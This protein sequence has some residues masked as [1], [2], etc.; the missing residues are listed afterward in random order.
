MKFYFSFLFCFISL[1]SAYAQTTTKIDSLRAA[2]EKHNKQDTTA[3]LLMIEIAQELKDKD[4]N[5]S[6]KFAESA[7]SLSEKIKYLK[8]E[9]KAK[10]MI[11]WRHYQLGNYDLCFDISSKALKI[12]EDIHDFKEKVAILNSLGAAY[13]SQQ[14]YKNAVESFRKGYQIA[15]EN[16]I[17]DQAGRSLNNIAFILYKDNLLQE[18]EEAGKKALAYNLEQENKTFASVAM[19]TLGDI[20]MQRKNY[21]KAESYYKKSLAICEEVKS[22][23][24]TINVLIRLGRINI[25]RKN[26][27]EAIE[28]LLKTENLSRQYSYRDEL[29]ESY[30]YLSHSYKESKQIELAYNYLEKYKF[31]YDS[32]YNDK[33][34]KRIQELS[35]QF[36]AEKKQAQ[37][38][39]LNKEKAIKDEY[40][41]IQKKVNYGLIAGLL[42]VLSGAGYV[43]YNYRAKQKMNTLLE[44]QKQ[45]ITKK[46][47]EV[48][49]QAEE[50]TQT[51]NA[52]LIANEEIN[53]KNHNITASINYAKKIQSAL[54][55]SIS[56]INSLFGE[57]NHFLL[58]QPK[59]ILS[60]DFYWVSEPKEDGSFCFVLADCTGHG[61]PGALMSIIGCEL[62]HQIVN[63]K[64]IYEP[65]EILNQLRVEL[66]KVLNQEEVDNQDGMDLA[67]LKIDKTNKKVCFAGAMNSLY[68]LQTSISNQLQEIKGDKIMIGGRLRKK[69][70]S[71]KLHEIDISKKTYFYLT[72]DG[73][74]DQFGGVSN[75]KYSHKRLKEKLQEI[76]Q[77][78]LTMQKTILEKELQDWM[79]QGEEVQIDDIAL[80]GFVL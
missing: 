52:I 4:N 65:D 67:V 12:A 60:G 71:F 62:L 30:D 34:A 27:Q 16:Q 55:P 36:E 37:I 41:Q 6:L 49:A 68:Y 25:Q 47:E 80:F 24:L 45:E 19:R 15:E 76:H 23:I 42:L 7:D 58:Y 72:S 3:V 70:V 22:N 28:Y 69:D 17:H 66:V 61:V 56:T 43:F 11:G 54:L 48:E 21:D 78:P 14:D 5:Q 53:K 35:S 32:I 74:K 59:D 51:N 50:L 44:E 38:E 46:H 29:L 31:L 57:Q 8:G 13:F 77:Q 1:I 33:N 18:A 40:I 2:F 64:Q 20:E 75:K 26:Y 73:F 39:L 10:S 63:M 9:M 79:S